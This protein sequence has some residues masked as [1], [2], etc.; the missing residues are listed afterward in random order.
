VN[1]KS[2]NPRSKP[3]LRKRHKTKNIRRVILSKSPATRP[4][5]SGPPAK[6]TANTKHLW[7]KLTS[8]YFGRS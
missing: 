6:T 4:S 7:A 5:S 3:K 8:F 2:S 1:K